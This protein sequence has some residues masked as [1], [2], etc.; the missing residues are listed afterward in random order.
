MVVTVTWKAPSFTAAVIAASEAI[1]AAA[2]ALATLDTASSL[3]ALSVERQYVRPEVDR[4]LD[5]V[6]AGGRHVVVEQSIETPFVANVSLV[7]DF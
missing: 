7:A 3:A 6:I 5:F 4:S 1:K 2:D